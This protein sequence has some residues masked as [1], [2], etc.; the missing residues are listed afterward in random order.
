[1]AGIGHISGFSEAKKG[2]KKPLKNEGLSVDKMRRARDSNP[3]RRK[4]PGGLAIRCNTIMRTL[5][6]EVEGLEPPRAQT[7]RFS[8]PLSY[9]LE[10]NLQFEK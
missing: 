3:H 10:L 5:L 2:T 8:R 1:M 6:A 4:L 7:R 9:Q